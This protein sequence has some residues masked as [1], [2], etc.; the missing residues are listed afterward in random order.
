MSAKTKIGLRVLLWTSCMSVILGL[1]S[2]LWAKGPCQKDTEKFCSGVDRGDGRIAKCLKNNKERLSSECSTHIEKM[3]VAMRGV[4]DA[5][6]VDV[7]TVCGSVK[8]GAGRIMKCMKANHDKLSE[9]C[10]KEIDMRKK[11]SR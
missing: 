5:C 11:V 8:P 10:K 4:K 1:Q 2:P 6:R 7:E 9:A 3:R